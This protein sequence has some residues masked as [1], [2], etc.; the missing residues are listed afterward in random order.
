MSK[1][2]TIIL[3]MAIIPFFSSCSKIYNGLKNVLKE[4][5]HEMEEE[6]KKPPFEP[7]EGY[8]IIT[9]ERRNLKNWHDYKFPYI[10]MVDKEVAR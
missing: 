4:V 2:R 10:L 3:I 7:L 5:A 6:T 1:I 8:K 9:I